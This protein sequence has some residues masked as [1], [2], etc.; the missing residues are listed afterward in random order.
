M[1]RR[2]LLLVNE[3]R[4]RCLAYLGVK[5]ASATRIAVEPATQIAR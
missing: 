1:L 4:A 3:S 2:W 5:Y